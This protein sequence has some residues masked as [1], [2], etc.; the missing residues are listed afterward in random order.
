ML[1]T[2]CLLIAGLFATT[3]AFAQFVPK[4][5]TSDS[6]SSSEEGG[7]ADGGRDEGLRTYLG[8]DYVSGE[9]STSGGNSGSTL[10]NTFDLTMLRLRGGARLFRF[11]SAEVQYGTSVGSGSG[12]AEV[13]NY[14]G[15]L[16]VPT[17]TVLDTFELSLP[18]GWSKI[19][20]IQGGR[21]F[22]DS[23]ITYGVQA[24]LPIKLFADVP[25][26]RI[27][28]GFTTFHA[29][30]SSRTYGFNFGL[31]YD[32]APSEFELVNPITAISE[33]FGGGDDSAPAAE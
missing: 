18:V 16:L 17:A 28:G 13:E 31:R 19:E 22:D 33:L 15:L 6:S 4:V 3:S 20:V 21:S 14:L 10:S 1:L 26:L 27:G 24:D 2:R 8:F 29:G 7:G 25:D 5:Q 32:F 12:E 11:I 9:F 23:D 30:N